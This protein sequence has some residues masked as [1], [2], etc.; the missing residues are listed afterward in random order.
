MLLSQYLTEDLG[1]LQLEDGHN[2]YFIYSEYGNCS[3]SVIETTET[4]N[5][6]L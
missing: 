6:V 2:N 3:E 1:H 4:Q 5:H